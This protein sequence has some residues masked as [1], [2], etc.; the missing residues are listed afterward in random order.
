MPQIDKPSLLDPLSSPRNDERFTIDGS[1]EL[2]ERL[3]H[4]C[5]VVLASLQS[6]LPKRS[7]EGLLL[8][9]GYGRGEGSVLQTEAGDLPYNDLEFYAFLRGAAWWNERRYAGLFHRL[10]E[11]LASNA[12]VAVEF[13]I[14]SRSKLRH[15]PVSMFYYDLVLGHH[16][17]KGGDDLL[18][19]CEHHREASHIQPAEA[20]RLLMNR[21]TGL[22]LSRQRL[23]STSFTL[24]DADF[25]ERNLAK[26]QLAFGDVILTVHGQYHWSCLERQRRLKRL[27]SGNRLA[28]LSEAVDH[29]A[30]GVEF[31]L[32]PSSTP[33]PLNILGEQYAT[34]SAFALRLWLW[35][36][37]RRLQSDFASAR[38]YAF[39]PLNKCPETTAWR[40]CLVNAKALSAGLVWTSPLSR[41]PREKLL[42]TLPLLL[43]ECDRELDAAALR[44]LQG[45]LATRA[46]DLPGLV[47]AY[48][49]LWRHF[50]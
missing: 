15:S 11:E 34:L 8:A 50:N 23:R 26:A 18:N 28:W 19:G 22:L 25:V 47:K 39:S 46:S 43:W 35:L 38:D 37:S 31:K 14:I 49:S 48:E 12:G 4:T 9:G 29:H 32:H 30:V 33:S 20:T 3:R 40:N 36:E 1:D 6:V 21:C 5:Q 13:K 44:H 17:I 16:R 7:L 27:V 41:Y 24:Q 2:E 45:Q 10:G 42:N